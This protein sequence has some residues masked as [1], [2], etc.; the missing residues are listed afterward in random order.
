M[1]QTRKRASNSE[2]DGTTKKKRVS[3][4]S[5]AEQVTRDEV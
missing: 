4:D 2:A 5:K 3:G 1:Q